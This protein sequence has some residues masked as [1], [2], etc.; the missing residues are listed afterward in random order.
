[1]QTAPIAILIADEQERIL[2][3]NRAAEALFGRVDD[4]TDEPLRC[5][6]V[7]ACV[8]RHESPGGCGKGE[9]C[10]SCEVY[11][12]IRD[13]LAGVT[14]DD[15]ETEI[16]IENNGTS[17]R[18]QILLSAAPLRL[19]NRPGVILAA[20]DITQMRALH[21]KM[22]QSD[23]LSSMGM[24]AAGVAHEINNPLSY[25]LYNLESLT[26]DLP[27][28]Q[29]DVRTVQARFAAQYDSPPAE[30]TDP[31]TQ[32]MNPAMLDDI[33]KRFEDA[34]GGT[35]RIRDIARGLGTFSR[36]ERDKLVPVNLMHVIE[37]A[38]NMSYNEIKYRAR[39]V[40]E[41]GR[42][43]TI[44]ASEGR[45]SQ[46]FL[47]LIINATHAIEEGDVDN[48]E[49][50]VRTWSDN[51]HVYAEIRDSGSG[52]A[53]ENMGNLFEPFFSTKEIGRGSGL[54]LAISKNIIEGYGGDISVESEVGKGTSFTL[55]IPIQKEAK[56]AEGKQVIDA[57]ST[58]AKGRILIVDDEDG[59]RSAMVRMLRGHET[60]EASSG[61]AARQL[62]E[63]D[64][65][66]D[67]ILCDMMMPAVSGM[68]LHQWLLANHPVLAERL[69]FVTGG[70]FTPKA[71][72]Y[73]RKVDNLRL[74]KP[75]DVANLKKI[76]NDHVTLARGGRDSV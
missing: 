22:A 42:I 53:A 54:G 8:H 26:E 23:R 35:R 52:I 70:A 61:A 20:N 51:S 74:E 46:V 62:L 14:V 4:I 28:L 68:D 24:L 59:I 32:T 47:N 49:I 75:F 31:L 39:L 25:V 72:E 30:E 9:S 63:K 34:L 76:V 11:R 45:L 18:R 38:I 6:D 5:G 37:V 3:A 65:G 60:V 43:P 67:L 40:K 1:M 33:L 50:R 7:I 41:Y 56:E 69:I 21:A 73:L 27:K 10:T 12:A 48:N 44:M 17:A 36:V 19:G 55:R 58:K 2:Q 29:D 66:F 16:H 15:L 71:R 57:T 64:Q 13:G